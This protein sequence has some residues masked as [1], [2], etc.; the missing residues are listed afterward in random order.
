MLLG[1]SVFVTPVSV[2]IR[3]WNDV[4]CQYNQ[5]LR[6][7]LTAVIVVIAVIAVTGER[8]MIDGPVVVH[9]H[10]DLISDRNRL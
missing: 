9:R 5:W 10:R 2:C 4:T 3:A 1:L 8:V 6:G 7:A